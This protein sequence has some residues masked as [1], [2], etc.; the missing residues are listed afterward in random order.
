M[1]GEI[2]TLI[3]KNISWKRPTKSCSLVV[4]SNTSR[5]ISRNARKLSSS[6]L[7]CEIRKFTAT[8]KKFCEINFALQFT[9]MYLDLNLSSKSQFDGL[10]AKKFE[11]NLSNYQKIHNRLN[12]VEIT[13]IL[14]HFFDKTFRESKAL[15]NKLLKSWFHEIFCGERKFI[16]FPHGALHIE[17]LRKFQKLQKFTLCFFGEKLR[18]SNGFYYWRSY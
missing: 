8:S 6:Q 13:E 7:Q 16:I 11:E 9:T 10:F 17:L 4:Y 5:L 18:E 3:S 1:W 14:S 2:F 15:L 12:I